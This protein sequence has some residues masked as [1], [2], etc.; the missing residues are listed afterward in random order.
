[1]WVANFAMAIK[2]QLKVELVLGSLD[3]STFLIY[4]AGNNIGPF[5]KSRNNFGR[6]VIMEEW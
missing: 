2:G 4:I 1:V 3:S 5:G 6:V